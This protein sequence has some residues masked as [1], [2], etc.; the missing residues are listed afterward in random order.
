MAIFGK[1]KYTIVKLRKKE[2]PDGLWT[3]CKGCGQPIYNKSVARWEAYKDHIGELF[4]HI[5]P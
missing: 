3:K 2:M 4:D 1:P 5:S